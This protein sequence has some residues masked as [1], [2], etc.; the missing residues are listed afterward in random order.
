MT[1]AA[2]P[3]LVV[4]IED[5][6]R[7]A[8]ALA[9]LL[10]DWGYECLHADDVEEVAGL[11]AGR[12]HEV[13]AII[14]DYHLHGGQTGLE[15]IARMADAGVTAPALLLTATLGG[16]ARRVSSAAGYPYMEKPVAPQR[17]K[18]WLDAQTGR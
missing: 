6:A 9:T 5:D 8:E 2:R 4:V 14:S 16:R 12:S 18:A 17:L 3:P 11:V 10:D 13:G 15:A 1:A 7:A